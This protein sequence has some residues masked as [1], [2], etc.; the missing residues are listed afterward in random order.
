MRIF[1][2]LAEASRFASPRRKAALAEGR[3]EEGELWCYLSEQTYFVHQTGQA[4]RFED[5]LKGVPAAPSP[6]VS[7][8][9]ESREEA[10]S[11]RAMLL[12]RKAMGETSEPEEVQSALTL[13]ALL[14]FLADTGQIEDFE[15][16]FH[17]RLEYAPMAIASFGSRDEAEAWFKSLA[18]PPSPARILIGDQYHLAWYSREDGAQDISRDDVIEPYIEGLTARGIPPDAPSFKTREEA[19]AWLTNH[20]AAPF[21]FIS[22][23]GEYTLAVHHKR[24]KLHTLYPVARTLREWEERKAG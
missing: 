19:E 20:P 23:D 18:E 6:Y 12:I 14:N 17:H 13:L 3:R 22:I 5:Y 7:A 15:D 9:L 24:L 8:A 2:A 11:Q 4:Y 10:T 21:E 16:F 1:E